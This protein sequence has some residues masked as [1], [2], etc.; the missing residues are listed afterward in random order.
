MK[1]IWP[2]K[3]IC[4]TA[5]VCLI[6]G[7]ASGAHAQ[8]PLGADSPLKIEMR[9]LDA[10]FKNVIDDILLGNLSA[11]EGHL[12][13]IVALKEKTHE[14]I[15]KGE[16]KLLKNGKKTKFFEELD[17]EFHEKLER[18]IM[19]SKKGDKKAV[20][21]ITHRLLDACVS[22]HEAFRQ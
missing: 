3:M 10:A 14:A 20:T 16:I 7:F 12:H 8:G 6:P 1:M 9:Q 13:E 18:L 2:V 17:A 4:F 15:E 22:C 19:A 21:R 5:C 11:I